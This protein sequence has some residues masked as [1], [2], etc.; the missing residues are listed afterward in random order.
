MFEYNLR[1]ENV[2]VSYGGCDVVLN[3]FPRLKKIFFY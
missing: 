3:N 1:G 2:G